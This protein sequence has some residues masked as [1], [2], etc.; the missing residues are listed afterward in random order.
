M[1]V[2]SGR[3]LLRMHNIVTM[4]MTRLYSNFLLHKRWGSNFPLVNTLKSV[5][6]GKYLSLMLLKKLSKEILLSKSNPKVA[7]LSHCEK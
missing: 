3:I 2:V 1:Y 6:S 5:S 4:V 7:N